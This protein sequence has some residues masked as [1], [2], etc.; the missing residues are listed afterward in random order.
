MKRSLS[1]C[2]QL[3][4]TP[5]RLSIALMAIV[6]AQGAPASHG[7]LKANPLRADYVKLPLSFEPN[8]GQADK[9]VDF[10]AHG[11]GYGLFLSRAEAV[12]TF[13]HS[14]TTVRMRPTG[15][16]HSAQGE[17]LEKLPG[18][19]N[20]FI[21]NVPDRWR[22]GIPTYAKV[23][24]RSVYPGIDLIYHGNQRQL[25]YDFVVQPGADANE[26][27]LDFEGA[28][29]TELDREGNVRM[30][31]K[32]GDLRWHRPVAYQDVN[33]TRRLI[34]CNYVRRGGQQLAFSLDAYDRARPLVIDPV[35]D[36]STY[37]GGTGDDGASAIA[38]DHRGNAYVT[39]FTTSTD[40]PIK[41]GFQNTPGG[42]FVTKL[43]SDGRSVVYS[44][45]LGGSEGFN[46]GDAA[47][48]IAVDAQGQAYVTG[49]TD[50]TD[51]PTKNAFQTTLLAFYGNAFV[52]K[53]NS[54]GD[55]LVYS[56][57]LGGSGGI[58]SGQAAG[59]AGSGIAVDCAGHA[60]VTGY[61]SSP[62]FPIKNAF[63]NTLKGANTGVENAFVTKFEV[64][65]K[66]L[67][68]STYLG[69]SGNFVVVDDTGEA[70]GDDGLGI[71]V[72]VHGNAYVTGLTFS[73]DFPTKNA[74]QN[75]FQGQQ[76]K[77]NLCS[78]V[79]VT[80]L[81]AD[82]DSLI[83]STYLGGSGSGTFS[84]DFGYSIA[85][86]AEGHAYVTG[87]TSSCDFPTKNAFQNTLRSTSGNAFVTKFDTDGDSLIYS[88]YLGGSSTD[89]GRGI[90][91]DFHGNAYVTGSTA[92][93]DFPTKDA[94]QNTLR[95]TS[96]NAFVT[97]F[98]ADGDSLVYSSYLGGSGNPGGGGDSG[99]GIAVDPHGHAYVAGETFSPDFPTRNAFQATLQ[100]FSDAFVTKIW[101]K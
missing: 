95:S 59:D 34:A 52:A 35:F 24:Y 4:A 77:C 38:V 21:G 90:A 74:F 12:L 62:D 79:F 94:F 6:A 47:A 60:Y 55:S 26:I 87:E 82:G 93:A 56:T 13:E 48:G 64:D 61:A 7:N 20:Y 15:G 39:G 75:H 37:L 8:R 86:D 58:I 83:Y 67:M 65:G 41:N 84:G 71:A 68:Y 11:A 70:A 66:S 14:A 28:T 3:K 23:R 36:Y 33:G 97:K 88:T 99:N 29:N 81:D 101:G 57:Y 63:Q 96:G 53:L 10:L 27:L 80:K 91:V 19:S 72:D 1:T 31:T 98:D 40:F 43:D 76:G 100:G 85:V 44:T 54:D 69:G 73:S 18:K 49:I 2:M 50:S 25:E 22:T 32:R 89:T 78:N 9:Q 46:I 17:A 5:A 16:N 92:S 45:Y 42:A 30:H 51:F